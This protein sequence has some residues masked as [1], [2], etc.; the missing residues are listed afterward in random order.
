MQ[1][2]WVDGVQTDKL[3][4]VFDDECVVKYWCPVTRR[5][6][7]MLML[8]SNDLDKM[9]NIC[10]NSKRVMGEGLK[11]RVASATVI[12]TNADVTDLLL[13]Y[14]GPKRNFHQMKRFPIRY[15]LPS[16]T[17][18]LMLTTTFGRQFIYTW[19]DYLCPQKGA[20]DFSVAPRREAASA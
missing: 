17:D 6:Y 15:L 7:R 12:N 13:Q 5:M 9:M 16:K 14:A 8:C 18:K 1:I 11:E 19:Y 3:P 2:I 20:I 4:S 10:N